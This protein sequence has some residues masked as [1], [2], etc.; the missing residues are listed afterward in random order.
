MFLKRVGVNELLLCNP[1]LGHNGEYNNGR[2]PQRSVFKAGVW[3][4]HMGCAAVREKR[5]LGER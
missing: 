1:V 2:A 4:N 5:A 3:G